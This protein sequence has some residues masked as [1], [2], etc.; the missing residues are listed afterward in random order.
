MNV[1][2]LESFYGGSHKNFVDGFCKFWTGRVKLVSLPARFWKWRV[3]GAAFEFIQRI[4]PAEL[5]NYDLVFV[6]SLISVVELKAAW[7]GLC[8]PVILYMHESQLDYPMSSNQALDIHFVIN[9]FSNF[10]HAD[11]I[12]FNSGTHR[13]S[14]LAKL[15]QYL[16]K[17]PDF[18]PK[19]LL[20][21]LSNKTEV[22]YPGCHFE[23]QVLLESWPKEVLTILWNHRWEYDK[24]PEDFFNVL[25][26]LKSENVAFRLRVL[27]ENYSSKPSCFDEA[28]V[29]LASHID[30]WGY[31]SSAQAYYKHLAKSHIIISTAIQENFGIAVVEAMRF[32]CFP[33]LPRRLSYP[34]ILPDDFHKE[35]LYDSLEELKTKLSK[36]LDNPAFF[37][38][39]SR[40]I[41]EKMARYSWR[42]QINR[43]H[44]LLGKVVGDL[45]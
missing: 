41:S 21:Q 17:L 40:K 28:R 14:C 3:R 25:N 24:C 39:V 34:E 31:V 11:K 27:G 6:T 15:S 4:D 7:G 44:E 35:C 5:T 43:Y 23:E 26:K 42:S 38:N 8:P 16:N 29:Q 30:H 45:C 18:A 13:D 10:V 9:D 12:L 36:I 22:V 19:K 33:L 37:E 20:E 1:L 2:F 32:G